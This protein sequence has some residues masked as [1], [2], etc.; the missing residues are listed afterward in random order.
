[1]PIIIDKKLCIGCGLCASVCP[2]NFK[3]NDD[4]KAEAINQ[5]SDCA[6]NAS[7]S[8]PVQAIKIK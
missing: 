4:G 1:M 3:M 5:K 8:C 2:S 6:K 7:E